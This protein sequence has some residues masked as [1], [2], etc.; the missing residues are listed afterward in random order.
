MWIVQLALRRPYTFVVAAFLV[1][2]LGLLF[3]LGP[4]RI[5][6]PT[7]IFP[8][9]DIPVIAVAF[10]YTGMSPADMELRIVGPFERSVTTTVN[11]VEHTESQ[12]LNGIG[13]VKVYFQKNASI[14]E[15]IAQ[16]TAI[17]QTA[18]R[19]MPPGTQPPLLTQYNAADVPIIQLSISSDTIPEA[20]LFDIA[21][22]DIRPQLVNIP[23][24]Q[25]P[26]PY[27]GKQKN[28]VV[29]SRSWQ[30]L[31]PGHFAG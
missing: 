2:I 22:N 21:S 29:R 8:K 14:Q 12:S 9:I 28:I 11:D 23:G 3:I 1:A 24:L 10:N 16:V 26:A 7:D 30:T 27:G 5:A 19:S 25:S 20:K 6:M 4:A 13:I 31:R 15:A 18:I 17:S